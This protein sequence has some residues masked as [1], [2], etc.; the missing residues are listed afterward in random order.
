MEIEVDTA[1]FTPAHRLIAA[2]WESGGKHCAEL[3]AL[4]MTKPSK[5]S[6]YASATVVVR[7]KD[8]AG[9]DTD[10][11]QCGDYRLINS[12]TL[13]DRYP[14]PRIDD[15]FRDMKDAKIFNKV[16]CRTEYNRVIDTHV[17]TNNNISDPSQ[18]V[19][20]YK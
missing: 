20:M 13:L 16:E 18:M 12:H 11:T 6:K 15:I 8:E 1:I 3:G 10:Y 7:K 2:E 4:G 17:Q 14:L 19:K 5:Q 9:E